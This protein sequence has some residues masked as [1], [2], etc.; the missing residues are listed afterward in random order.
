MTVFNIEVFN[1]ATGEFDLG[2]VTFTVPTPQQVRFVRQ[3]SGN[4]L[5][6]LLGTE[7][8]LVT[9]L[10][11]FCRITGASRR[12]VLGSLTVSTEQARELGFILPEGVNGNVRDADVLL[13]A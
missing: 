4:V 12:S 8:R 11:A 13:P 2:T 5:V 3:P 7:Q 6:T 9:S 1:C 10:G